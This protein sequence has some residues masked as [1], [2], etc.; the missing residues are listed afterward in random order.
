MISIQERI[1]TVMSI[2]NLTNAEFANT[3]GVQPSNISHLLSGRNKPSLDLIMKIVKRFP[4][5]RLDWL[6]QGD[7]SMNKEYGED[8][9]GAHQAEINEKNKVI[10]SDNSKIQEL[11][12]N[13]SQISFA[14]ETKKDHEEVKPSLNQGDKAKLKS[15]EP[16]T[17]KQNLPLQE[18]KSGAGI[19]KI[20]IFYQ[21]K[22]F[23]EYAPKS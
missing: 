9:S 19:E 6:L 11:G 5:I 4:E 10:A 15:N 13:Q 14:F 3:I 1:S 18:K 22:T 20:V 21:D 2:K 23:K 17:E 7:G 8:W 16:G 12:R